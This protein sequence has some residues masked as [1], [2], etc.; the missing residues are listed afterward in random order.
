MHRN[1][2]LKMAVCSISPTGAPAHLRGG[3]SAREIYLHDQVEVRHKQ[4]TSTELGAERGTTNKTINCYIANDH[5][6]LH[7]RM[8][9]FSIH[10]IEGGSIFTC[11]K[12]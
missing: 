2:A 9:R 6:C 4:D 10:K 5:V 11:K 3:A 8:L 1:Q 7:A 12:Q